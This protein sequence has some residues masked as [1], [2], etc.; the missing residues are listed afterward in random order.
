MNELFDPDV[1]FQTLLVD[2]GI[3]GVTVAADV[4]A[5]SFESVPIIIHN[6]QI[7]QDRNGP[8][9]WTCNLSIT[10]HVDTDDPDHFEVVKAVYAGVWSWDWPTNGIVPD[11]AAVES[12]DRDNGAFTRLARG[13][14]MLNKVVTPYAGV[15]ELTL[16]N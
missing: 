10:I 6:A 16:R 9:L 11:V 1:L 3:P 4:D 12:V 2:L 7:S 14:P 5:D 15:F 13:V 8:G